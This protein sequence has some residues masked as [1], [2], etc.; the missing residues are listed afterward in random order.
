MEWGVE[1]AKVTEVSREFTVEVLPGI[2]ETRTL[3]GEGR[4]WLAT[5]EQPVAWSGSCSPA[6]VMV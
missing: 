2:S 5:P 4:D 3:M 6:S 1:A